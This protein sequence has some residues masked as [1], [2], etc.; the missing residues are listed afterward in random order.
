MTVEQH[1]LEDQSNGSLILNCAI[2]N[3]WGSD[4]SV[5]A[6]ICGG[7]NEGVLQWVTHNIDSI[8]TCENQKYRGYTIHDSNG[9]QHKFVIPKWVLN[10]D[11]GNNWKY[12][13]NIFNKFLKKIYVQ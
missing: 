10:K 6:E 13:K 1:L 4:I 7:Y 11:V 3:K 2:T 12:A 9:N 5:Y 8:D